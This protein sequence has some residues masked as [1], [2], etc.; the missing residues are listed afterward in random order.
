MSETPQAVGRGLSVKD[1]TH[2]PAAAPGA[3][4]VLPPR[5]PPSRGGPIACEA[6]QVASCQLVVWLHRA[7]RCVQEG[8]S[9]GGC[10]GGERERCRGGTLVCHGLIMALMKL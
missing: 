8:L 3:R 9:R 10:P 4:A 1:A 7:T 2:A 6:G 5:G